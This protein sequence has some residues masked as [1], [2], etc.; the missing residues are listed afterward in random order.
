MFM[1]H[2]ADFLRIGTETCIDNQSECASIFSGSLL[3]ECFLIIYCV[4][5]N[6]ATIGQRWGYSLS[7]NSKAPAAMLLNFFLF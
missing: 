2:L 5:Q 6:A 3:Y 4:Y 1:W 7:L